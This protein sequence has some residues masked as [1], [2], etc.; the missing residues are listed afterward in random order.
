MIAPS[1]GYVL[2]KKWNGGNSSET[3]E[4]G[5]SQWVSCAEFGN[6]TY[7]NH[8]SLPSPDDPLVRCFH[9][10]SVAS[11]VSVSFILIIWISRFRP[12]FWLHALYYSSS[13]DSIDVAYP[14]H[15]IYFILFI[16]CVF[17]Q[18]VTEFSE[19]KLLSAFD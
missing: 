18:M 11:A 2:E 4:E 19:L 3:P 17:I 14:F 10:F 7:W 6:L 16:V 12:S 1:V 8:D 5:V 15:I 13:L 9:W